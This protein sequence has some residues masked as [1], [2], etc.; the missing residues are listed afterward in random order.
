MATLEPKN[1]TLNGMEFSIGRL[2]LFDA[3]NVSRVIAPVLP[4]LLSETLGA[5]ARA[6]DTSKSVDEATAEDRISELGKLIVMS[7]PVFKQIAAMPRADFESV[8]RTCLSACEI[9][10]GKTW[11]K[12]VQNGA[13]M[14]DNID[15]ATALILCVHVIWRELN[16]I[17]GA[18]NLSA[19]AGA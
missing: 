14:F 15:Q 13:V 4:V 1:I 9:R 16:P 17:I 3:L 19:E 12:V 2:D 5:V 10:I 7:E 8:V 11:S 6:L 18:L